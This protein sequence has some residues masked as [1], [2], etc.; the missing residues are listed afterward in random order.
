MLCV[1]LLNTLTSY[2]LPP[3]QA[4]SVQLLLAAGAEKD[5]PV[6]LIL[7]LMLIL[8]LSRPRPGVMQHCFALCR[9]W[10]KRTGLVSLGRTGLV[11]L[12]RA[13]LVSLGL[14]GASL[15]RIASPIYSVWYQTTLLR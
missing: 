12:G 1:S 9:V 2:P 6:I 7:V 15:R 8:M 3:F 13:G 4:E 11:S 10:V 14:A 5:W